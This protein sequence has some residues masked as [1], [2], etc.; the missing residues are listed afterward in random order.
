MGALADGQGLGMAGGGS[1][2]IPVQGSRPAVIVCA[3]CEANGRA[4]GAAKAP[5]SSDWHPVSH[6]YVRAQKRAGRASHGIC[7]T[8]RPGVLE[9]WGL[10]V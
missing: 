8:C 9:E 3:W 6:E 1:G 10:P 4:V 2:L 7:P 5:Q